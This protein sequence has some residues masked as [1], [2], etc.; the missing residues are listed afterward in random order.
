[1]LMNGSWKYDLSHGSR[2]QLTSSKWGFRQLLKANLKP[3]DSIALGANSLTS[4][5][6]AQYDVQLW[7]KTRAIRGVQVTSAKGT[8]RWAQGSADFHN[9]ADWQI[10][11]RSATSDEVKNEVTWFRSM[12]EIFGKRSDTNFNSDCYNNKNL[13]SIVSHLSIDDQKVKLTKN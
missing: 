2:L 8:G 5:L 6:H 11:E 10:F 7:L 9:A 1:M 3:D 12:P 13:R 4:C